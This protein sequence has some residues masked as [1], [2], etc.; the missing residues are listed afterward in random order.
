MESA[1]VTARIDATMVRAGEGERL[2][3][4]GD[5]VRVLLDSAGSGGAIAAFEVISQPGGGPPLH[6]HEKED[7]LFFV[8][9][10]EATFVVG[11]DRHLIRSGE[12]IFAPRGSIHT[13][14]NT[15]A[16]TLRM[17]VVCTS[18]GLERPF[19]EVDAMGDGMTPER[20]MAAFVEHGVRFLGPPIGSE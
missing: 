5:I 2:N 16:G 18:G 19:R 20:L 17:I 12:S 15:G 9:E 10:G 14:G 7:E 3:V 13:F 11:G 4:A 1:T 6:R 8:L